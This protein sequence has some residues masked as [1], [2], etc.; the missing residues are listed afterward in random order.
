VLAGRVRDGEGLD[1]DCD[2]ASSGVFANWDS[3][4]DPE[5]GVHRYEV[6]AGSCRF[7]DDLANFT[8][9]GKQLS[10]AWPHVVSSPGEMV[11]VTV[12]ALNGCGL[13]HEVSSDGVRTVCMA[14][15]SCVLD[16]RYMCLSFTK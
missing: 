5:S 8:S 14:T 4:E 15:D 3:F 16:A 11:Y 6:A 10:V 7:C 2:L 9:V 12:R 1:M 13:V